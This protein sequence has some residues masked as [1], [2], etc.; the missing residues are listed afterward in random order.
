MYQTPVAVSTRED[1]RVST[2][3]SV[4]DDESVHRGTITSSNLSHMY[5]YS[6]GGSNDPNSGTRRSGGSSTR[7][8]YDRG[9]HHDNYIPNGTSSQTVLTYMTASQDLYT[10]DH[11]FTSINESLLGDHLNQ[12]T[13][14]VTLED[15]S[16]DT[17]KTPK[18]P[19]VE[20]SFDVDATPIIDQS[21]SNQPQVSQKL[22]AQE[23]SSKFKRLST[24]LQHSRTSG[25]SHQFMNTFQQNVDRSSKQSPRSSRNSK[26]DYFKNIHR[27]VDTSPRRSDDGL[28]NFEQESLADNLSYSDDTSHMNT[29]NTTTI[30][31]SRFPAPHQE[32]DG[33]I[34]VRQDLIQKY[35]E[36]SPVG[37]SELISTKEKNDM[38][39]QSSQ[40]YTSLSDNYPHGLNIV[41]AETHE[42]N[43][44]SPPRSRKSIESTTEE[45]LSSLFVRAL[46]PFDASTLQSESDASICLSFNKD[47]LAFVHSIDDSGWGEV[48]LVETLERGWIPMNYFSMAI[49]DENIRHSTMSEDEL[50][51]AIPNSHFL[52]PLFHACSA[53][54]VDPL[55]HK[56]RRGNYTFSIKVINSIRDGVR[57]LLQE[58]NCL[59]RS[60][61]IVTR[62]PVVR[63]CRKSLLADWYSL[64]VKANEFKGTSDYDKIEILTLLVYQVTIKAINFLQI[65]SIEST[66][67]AKQE[68]EKKI[69]QDMKKYPLLS[70]PPLAKKRV[71]E[72]NGLLYSYL[73]LIIGR[74]DLVEHN[75]IGTDVLETLIH[76]IILLLRELLFVSKSGS[77]FASEKPS[78]L[79]NSLDTLLS[80]VSNLVD[81]VKK[82]VTK[83]VAEN[84]QPFLIS[85]NLKESSDYF[86]TAEGKNI[87]QIASKIVRSISKTVVSIF[88]LL[89]YTGDF[90][91]TSERSYPDYSKMRITPEEFIKRCSIGIAKT[92]SIKGGPALKSFKPSNPKHSNRYSLIRSGKPGDLGFTQES[93]TMLH[94]VLS[95]HEESTPFSVSISE[96]EPFTNTEENV[97]SNIQDEL[98]VDEKG[99]LLGGSFRGLVYTL[100]NEN[101][102]PDYFFVS[103]LFICYRSFATSLDLTEELISRFDVADRIV[104]TQTKEDVSLEVK[105][106]N[107]RRLVIKM[108]Q[109]WMES[110]WN[111]EQDYNLLTTFINFFN[112]G[113]SQYL[114]L[115]ATKLI[116]IAVKLTTRPLDASLASQDRLFAQLVSRTI[117]STKAKRKSVF[118]SIDQQFNSRYSMVDGY[119]LSK[120]NTNSSTTSSLK[121]L[122]LP[123]PLGIGNQTSGA[124]TLLS[125]TQLHTIEKVNM[126]YRAILGANWCP[127]RRK[128]N[129]HT[130]YFKID[131]ATLLPKWFDVCDQSWVLSNYKPNLLDFNGL[132]IA[133]Q[134][135][136]I[137]SQIFCS[138]KPD[139]LLNEN[140]TTKRAY[141]KLAPNVRQ[142]LLFTNCLSAY[143]LES[144][145]SPDI[146]PKKRV[147]L[148]KTWLKIAIS[149]L[150]LRNF[151][152]LAAI[153]T[154]LQSHLVTRFTKVWED[155]SIKYQELYD[156]LSSIIHPE[157]NYNVYRTKMRN[158]LISNDYNVPVVPYFSLF[159][160][161][162]T[163]L[164]DGNPKYR[165][166]NTFLN[167]KLINIDKYL[168]IT[169]VIADIESLQIPYAQSK[170]NP[171]MN[172]RSSILSIGS[173]KTLDFDDYNIIPVVS[174]QEFI[175]LELWKVCQ[176]NKHEEDRAWKLSLNIQPRE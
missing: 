71:T 131:L 11:S 149:C 120:I 124:N 104:E 110:Y 103:T 84:N 118:T 5:Q 155:L 21:A 77:E 40:G 158:F 37:N 167:Q 156:Y 128:Q 1:T 7:L 92:N 163:F 140:F 125:K 129:I 60:N 144:I 142:S 25:H 59:S 93:A 121:S 91:L 122:T 83:T 137:E 100:T 46:H 20:N 134:L 70:S 105:V 43:E 108:F 99:N 24:T 50:K 28:E 139:E 80:L 72:I 117:T 39:I 169:R 164:A 15:L 123:M 159:L 94:N 78:D 113:V 154:S 89:D 55:S 157:K 98:L 53:F 86:Y 87:I 176:L 106:K 52:K 107:R 130:T 173:P 49:V 34:P 22:P 76:Q 62:M 145:L 166:A 135:T 18:I 119:E 3:L 115:E 148:I 29:A 23:L 45:S 136:L 81:G 147:N 161:D 165:K 63:K 141:L 4:Y 102:P 33:D 58:T 90:K 96:F 48:T 79:D 160:Q 35:D 17:D 153:I 171:A 85:L 146:S 174:L 138:I 12:G 13:A 19:Q 64:M 54:L 88:K 127:E 111:Q 162:L 36:L 14:N 152:S 69:R 74:L 95:S 27:T 109:L 150:Y 168:K 56:T 41:T 42:S 10:A 170:P 26:S 31:S 172:R 2:T 143:V 38:Y 114:P 57:L 116:N 51:A 151:N 97:S 132:E 126:T 101:A 68:N 133:K 47:S 8:S 30:I 16:L 82:L 32:Y 112:E 67:I 44:R 175:L 61:E 75:P 66:Q 6:Y 73:C 65:W 9:E